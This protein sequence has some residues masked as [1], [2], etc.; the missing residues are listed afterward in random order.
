MWA[1]F[2]LNMYL[3]N[4]GLMTH[5]S[6]NSTVSKIKGPTFNLLRDNLQHAYD[7]YVSQDDIDIGW[8]LP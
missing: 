3:F 4:D 7:A 2:I 1:N 6:P 8:V 5:V